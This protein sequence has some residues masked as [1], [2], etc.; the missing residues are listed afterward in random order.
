[1]WCDQ[2]APPGPS[3]RHSHGQVSIKTEGFG[4]AYVCNNARLY[5]Q[6]GWVGGVLQFS[7]GGCCTTIFTYLFHPL[8]GYPTIPGVPVAAYGGKG[9]LVHESV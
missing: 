3:R 4:F 9:A 2:L 6:Q 7:V 8:C 5:L 1:M